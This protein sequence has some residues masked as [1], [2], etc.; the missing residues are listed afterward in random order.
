QLEREVRRNAETLDEPD[1]QRVRLTSS[2][3]PRCPE[4]D[5]CVRLP[6][7]D[8]A[9]ED[10]TLQDPER[11][12]ITEESGHV[13]EQVV[14]QRLQLGGVS[15][16]VEAVVVERVDAVNHHAPGD[17]ASDRR[18]PILPEIDAAIFE[19]HLEDLIEGAEAYPEERGGRQRGGLAE[20]GMARDPRQLLRDTFR[21][22][23]EIDGARGHS[24]PRYAVELRQ[25]R[26]L[27]EGD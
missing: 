16:E 17:A 18:L 15:L 20:V 10:T 23:D 24:A 9:G 1:G 27:R 4:A 19:Q 6:P 14:M 5:R 25:L 3:T 21:R 11:L 13:H 12:R 7:L 22:Q 8:D 26:R 2:G